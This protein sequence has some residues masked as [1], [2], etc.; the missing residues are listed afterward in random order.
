MLSFWTHAIIIEVIIF[1]K[2]EKEEDLIK[3]IRKQ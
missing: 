1:F 2:D 3:E